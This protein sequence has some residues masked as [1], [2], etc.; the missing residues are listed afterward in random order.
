MV[1][2]D[3]AETPMELELML[4]PQ[5]T[6][7]LRNLTGPGA[8]HPDLTPEALAVVWLGRWSRR[9]LK[10]LDFHDRLGPVT[11]T[12]TIAVRW[13][14]WSNLR[15]YG[16]DLSWSPERA[17]SAVLNDCAARMAPQGPYGTLE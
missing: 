5:T 3:D 14:L 17:A 1:M 9:T 2:Q 12:M 6:E 4:A 16:V 13:P 11:E 10:Q 7:L 15:E 8:L